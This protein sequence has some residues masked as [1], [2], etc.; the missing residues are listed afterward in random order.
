MIRTA[1]GYLTGPKGDRGLIIFKEGV[2]VVADFRDISPRCGTAGGG[3][4]CWICK[5]RFYNRF[6]IPSP[7]NTQQR[8]N[9]TNKIE[10]ETEGSG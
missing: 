8:G 9:Y 5:T 7:V 1:C 6:Y 2:L 3:V 4:R 10:T